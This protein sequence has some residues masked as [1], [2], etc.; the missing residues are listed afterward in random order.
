MNG[1]KYLADTNAYIFLLDKHPAI[2]PLLDSEWYFSFITEI[3]LKGKHL[4]ASSELKNIDDLLSSCTKVTYAEEINEVTI[5]LKQQFKI[6]VPDA[7]IAATSITKNLP[8]ITF[9][10]GFTAIKSLDLVLLEP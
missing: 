9:D 1:H 3:E 2:R 4:I 5:S 8:L 6:K 10:K 7:I